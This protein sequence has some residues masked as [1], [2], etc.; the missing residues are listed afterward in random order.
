MSVTFR[1]DTSDKLLMK[2]LW[3]VMTHRYLPV[4]S[5]TYLACVIGVSAQIYG[6]ENTFNTILTSQTPYVIAT[7]ISLW[8]SGPALLWIIL[9]TNDFSAHRANFWYKASAITMSI[10]LA[11][12]YFLFPE[13]ERFGVR[14]YMVATIPVF[15]ILYLFF[16]KGGLPSF[17]AH[18]LSVLGLT[19]V[20]YGSLIRVLLY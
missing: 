13:I 7:I 8:V 3:E 12:S 2:E 5:M 10:L 11:L 18:P 6:I 17:A 4:L 20:L 14:P 19:F 15:V 16:I 1:R 9:K